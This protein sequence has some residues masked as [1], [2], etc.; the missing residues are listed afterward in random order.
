MLRPRNDGVAHRVAERLESQIRCQSA[1]LLADPSEYLS[2]APDASDVRGS[3]KSLRQLPT[4]RPATPFCHG[5]RKAVRTGGCPSLLQM[6]PL[7]CQTSRPRRTPRI[8]ELL[9][10]HASRICCTIRNAVVFRV[11]LQR[12]ITKKQYR[13]PKASVGTVKKSMAVMAL[14]LP[15][16]SLARFTICTSNRGTKISGR[17]F[18]VFPTRSPQPSR[19][20]TRFLNLGRR[21]SWESSWSQDSPSRSDLAAVPAGRPSSIAP[22]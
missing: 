7:R 13:K 16:T 18:G 21:R 2:R 11:T 4:Q 10:G 14:K 17:A 6:S 3:N 22:F 19:N 5:L 20:S 15:N 12:R 1:P 8:C 9:Y